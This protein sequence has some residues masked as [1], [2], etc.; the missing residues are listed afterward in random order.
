MF[1]LSFGTFLFINVKGEN[2]IEQQ[3]FQAY[4]D[5]KLDNFFFEKDFGFSSKTSVKDFLESCY[6][7]IDNKKE[8]ISVS[9]INPVLEKSKNFVLANERLLFL[10]DELLKKYERACSEEELE[11]DELRQIKNYQFSLDTKTK[12]ILL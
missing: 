4:S 8:K 12:R 9:L 5:L 2:M 7:F 3:L 10:F 11:R 6:K 1:L